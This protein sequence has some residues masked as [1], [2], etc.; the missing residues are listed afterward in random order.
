MTNN[1]SSKIIKNTWAKSNI[2]IC[3]VISFVY[4]SDSFLNFLITSALVKITCSLHLACIILYKESKQ[5]KKKLKATIMKL[6]PQGCP[7]PASTVA[8]N[9]WV[10]GTR[11]NKKETNKKGVS[12]M[13]RVM[14]TYPSL[15][16]IFWIGAGGLQ[17]TSWGSAQI[18]QQ[19]QSFW[20]SWK[21]RTTTNIFLVLLPASK[22]STT[23]DWKTFC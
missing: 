2:M 20:G 18:P 4:A 15:P 21:T 6:V 7:V 8:L 11:C 10:L 3:L 17:N 13:E 16:N 22:M 14:F 23:N 19:K 1:L 12:S 5:G 9:L